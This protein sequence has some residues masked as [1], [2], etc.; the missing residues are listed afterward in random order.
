VLASTQK[1]VLAN[2]GKHYTPP[3]KVMLANLPGELYSFCSKSSLL[4]PRVFSVKRGKRTKP[5][6]AGLWRRFELRAR[7]GEKAML[8]LSEAQY[9]ALVGGKALGQARPRSSKRPYKTRDWEA[10]ALARIN[11]AQRRLTHSRRPEL[12]ARPMID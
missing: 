1:I 10:F 2:L 8:R 11:E 9:S 12:R 7:H 3:K 5:N 4:L 6:K